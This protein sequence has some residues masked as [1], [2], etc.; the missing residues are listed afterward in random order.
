MESKSTMSE[1]LASLLMSRMSLSNSVCWA[2]PPPILEDKRI[3][4][5]ARS[6]D[7]RCCQLTDIQVM[8]TPNLKVPLPPPPTLRYIP[9]S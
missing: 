7:L 6:K 2:M 9:T 4:L 1:R 3:I 5:F 8:P